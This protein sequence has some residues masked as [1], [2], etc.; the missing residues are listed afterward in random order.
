[1]I[2]L[3]HNG[4]VYIAKSHFILRDGIMEA[5]TSPVIN[6]ENIAMWHPNGEEN[7]LT[8]VKFPS[9]FADFIM[10]EDFF[11]TPFDEK[12]LVFDTYDKLMTIVGENELGDGD[13]LPDDVVFAEGERVFLLYGNGVRVEVEG[14]HS[15]LPAGDSALALYDISE[16]ADPYDFLREAYRLSEDL[17]G[18][19]MFPAVVMRTGDSDIKIIER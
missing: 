19:V 9:R 4:S 3:K 7:R 2:I 6:E 1:M 10:Y 14:F 17:S 5:R 13:E 11:P 15:N 18:Q 8:A 16:I 12:H